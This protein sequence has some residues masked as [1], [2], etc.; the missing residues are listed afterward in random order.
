MFSR[1][2]RTRAVPALRARAQ[3]VVAARRMVTTNAAGSEL[4]HPVPK[5]SFVPD[6]TNCLGESD[7]LHLDH[8]GVPTAR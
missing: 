6:A 3:P 1:A 2:L 8:P 4:E 7:P 5:V